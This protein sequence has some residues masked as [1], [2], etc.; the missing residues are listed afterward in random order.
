M[1]VELITSFCGSPNVESERIVEIEQTTG[2]YQIPLHEF[3]KH[4]LLGEYAYYNQQSSYVACNVFDIS[5]ADAKEHFLSPLIVGFLSSASGIKDN[6]GFVSGAAVIDEMKTSG[7][8]DEQVRHSLKRLASKRLIET[9]HGHY[10]EIKVSDQVLPDE[11]LFRATS[12]GIYHTRFWM[13]SFAFLDA[14][15]TDTPIFD[16]AAR[17]LIF[18]L[19]SSMTINDR[20][21]R[22]ETFKG[23]L[24][25]QW[26]AAN[27]SKPYLDVVSILSSQEDS[28]ASVRRAV[29]GQSH[30]KRTRAPRRWSS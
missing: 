26:S 28:F 6:D 3:T 25:A 23:Y 10:R 2:S 15:C 9:P 1:V 24:E 20:L 19:A 16:L 11:F 4:A 21:K 29:E 14:M 5:M 12:I 30:H 7:F 22:T 8:I 17:E 27:I 13:G 18:E